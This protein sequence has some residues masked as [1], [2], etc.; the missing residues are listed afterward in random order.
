MTA[1]ELDLAAI[2][3]RRQVVE[4]TVDMTFVLAGNAALRPKLM[5]AT[6]L[7]A[8]RSAADVPSLVAEVEHLRELVAGVEA[9]ADQSG[10]EH[11]FR[12]DHAEVMADLTKRAA[13]AST[14]RQAFYLAG[15]A[16]HYARG[17]TFAVDSAYVGMI[18]ARNI[19]EQISGVGIKDH[20]TYG[21]G[22]VS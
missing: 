20:A 21:P 4:A 9:L 8:A 19:I 18:R 10:H 14:P 12:R 3:G 15:L 22:A 1:P 5:Q 17:E 6:A 7:A 11:E 13:S 2:H 16:V